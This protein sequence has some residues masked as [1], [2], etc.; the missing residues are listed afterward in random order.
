MDDGASPQEQ[1][2]FKE[3]V[4]EQVENAGGIGPDAQRHEHVT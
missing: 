3:G 4:R 2:R 1:K